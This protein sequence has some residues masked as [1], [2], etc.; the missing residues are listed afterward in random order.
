[1]QGTLGEI[2]LE[3]RYHTF[4][5][6]ALAYLCETLTKRLDICTIGIHILKA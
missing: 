6:S 3:A 2:F 1:M 4:S 5:V